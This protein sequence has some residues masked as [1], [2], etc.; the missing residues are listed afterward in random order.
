MHSPPNRVEFTRPQTPEDESA[1]VVPETGTFRLCGN[2]ELWY[3]MHVIKRKPLQ[4]FGEKHVDAAGPL[5]TWYHETRK[6]EWA[7]SMELKASYRTASIINAERVVFDIGGGKFR[8]VVRINYAS[9]TVF[10]RF[11]GTH[12]QYDRIDPGS[13]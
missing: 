11:V 4:D 3:S 1:E 5:Q 6:A 12:A 2:G 7:N 10:V 9:K 8:L 13:V